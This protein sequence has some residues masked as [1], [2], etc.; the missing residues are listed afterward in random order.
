[1]R[2]NQLKYF[3]SKLDTNFRGRSLDEKIVIFES[4]DWGAI[5]MPSKHVRDLLIKIGVNLNEEIYSMF[6]GL[7]SNDD[8]NILA[9]VISNYQDQ[10]GGHPIFTLNSVVAN[11]DFEGIRSCNFQIYSYENIR[12]TY[13]NY[14]NSNSVLKDIIQ[15]TEEGIFCPQFHG[16]EHV[17]VNLWLK[18]LNLG[19]PDFIAAF[20]NNVFGLNR[21]A[22]IDHNKHI[23]ATYDERDRDFVYESIST[24]LRM[25]EDVF[26]FKSQTFIPN[27][28][29][30]DT[31]WNDMLHEGGVSSIQG[32]KYL[33]NP[34]QGHG[35]RQ[36]MRLHNGMRS[37]NLMYT[38]RNI[39]FEPTEKLYSLNRSL[40]EI[41][42]SFLLKK[43]AIISTHRLNYTSRV[44]TQVRDNGIKQL[45]LLLKG[46][47]RRW[48]DVKFMSSPQY[49][50]YLQNV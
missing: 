11:P 42:L 22:T 15:R 26:G 2:Y 3:A 32:M 43:P 13:S 28:Y 50:D 23:Q 35:Q 12:E 17:N 4:D 37:S 18:L 1:M 24:G 6:D 27:N 20:D 46:I 30:W 5:R 47:L 8:V 38:V 7:E 36:K 34:I 39:D 29:I 19:N 16:R 44:T 33:L 45:E 9:N 25:F 21:G 31:D 49:S 41:K 40:M 10:F 14:A 48:P